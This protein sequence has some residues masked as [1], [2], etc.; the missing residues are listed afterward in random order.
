[1]KKINLD[2]VL[3]TEIEE[4]L[5]SI[6]KPEIKCHKILVSS[7]CARLN[8]RNS[9]SRLEVEK[10]T[11]VDLCVKVNS[12]MEWRGRSSRSLHD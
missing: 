9:H 12:M 11:L 5:F 3:K 2:L 8:R 7:R 10:M 6:S 1:M 4:E